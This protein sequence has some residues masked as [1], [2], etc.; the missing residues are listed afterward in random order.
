MK[1][2]ANVFY[3]RKIS[4]M[5]FQLTKCNLK[6]KYWNNDRERLNCCVC[7]IFAGWNHTRFYASVL[8]NL[9]LIHTPNHIIIVIAVI[10]CSPNTQVIYSDE[11]KSHK[12]DIFSYSCDIFCV[13]SRFRCARSITGN[14]HIRLKSFNA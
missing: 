4:L 3:R 1:G 10:K 6:Y 5:S 7:F 8:L 2:I 13:A 12:I 14:I 9:I 11:W